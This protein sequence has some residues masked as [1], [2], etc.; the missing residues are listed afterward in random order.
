[1]TASS[2]TLLKHA[3]GQPRSVA[4]AILR[5]WQRSGSDREKT[6]NCLLYVLPTPQNVEQNFKV[7]I[8]LVYSNAAEWNW[9]C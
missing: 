8:S 2:F 4:Q 9:I 3:A 6:A 1:M 7:I 5:D